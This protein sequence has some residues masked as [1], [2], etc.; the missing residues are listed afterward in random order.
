LTRLVILMD[1]PGDMCAGCSIQMVL[2]VLRSAGAVDDLGSV[3]VRAMVNDPT[4]KPVRSNRPGADH[5]RW[6]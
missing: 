5:Q 4:R 2:A 1:F 6:T 3:G